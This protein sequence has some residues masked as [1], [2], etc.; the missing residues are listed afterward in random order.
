MT[1]KG[2]D[3]YYSPDRPE[4]H[5]R[6]RV[7]RWLLIALMLVLLVPAVL[8]ALVSYQLRQM[9]RNVADLGAR[10]RKVERGMSMTAVQTIM[11]KSGAPA[12]GPWHAAWD[13][14]RLSDDEA[15]RITSA[16]CYTAPDF[17]IP[18]F[19]MITFDGD[20]KV[21]GKQIDD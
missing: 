5:R 3:L 14:E 16:L 8:L 13:T 15:K 6:P 21:V 2:G 7:R 18:A 12:R 17:P 4:W 20:G 19:V 1:R 10:Y 9:S 11:G